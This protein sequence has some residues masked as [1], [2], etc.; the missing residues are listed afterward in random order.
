MNAVSDNLIYGFH[1][2]IH[3]FIGFLQLK[4]ELCFSADKCSTCESNSFKNSHETAN[5]EIQ[6]KLF[7]YYKY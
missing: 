2:F 6:L 3:G 5:T 7:L 1:T 4:L